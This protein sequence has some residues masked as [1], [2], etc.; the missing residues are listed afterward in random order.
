[1]I[2]LNR[3]T[4]LATSVFTALGGLATGLP[5]R[6]EDRYLDI[7]P[8]G[9]FNPV[10]VAVT[11]FA[12]EASDAAKVTS[13]ITNNFRRSVYL[14]PLDGPQVAVDPESPALDAF[15][16]AGAQFVVTGRVDPQWRPLRYRFPP[17]RGRLGRA[18]GGSALRYGTVELA[19]RRPHRVGRRLHPDHGRERF[20]RLARRLRRRKRFGR[21]PSQAPRHHGSGRRQREIPDAGR[22]SR[23]DAAFSRPPPSKSPIWRSAMPI[24]RCCCST[25]RPVSARTSATFRA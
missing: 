15:K 12:G 22:Q 5:A 24:L 21:E 7:R 13:I 25:S 16:T 18:G 6:A 17:V 2:R 10:T 19:S 3:R 9:S 8:G 1:M 14:K 20:L 11:P 23:G 4:L